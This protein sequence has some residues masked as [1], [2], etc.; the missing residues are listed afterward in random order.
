MKKYTIIGGVMT[1]LLVCTFIVI[2]ST[3]AN[4][5]DGNNGRHG[6]PKFEMTDEMKAAQEQMDT[7]I[8]NNDYETWK[9]LV[10]QLPDSS[11]MQVTEEAFAKLVER[12][13]DRVTMEE[14]QKKIEAAIDSGDYATWKSL[15]TGLPN[16]TEM[17]EKITAD[18]FAKFT[19]AHQLMKEAQAKMEEAKSIMEEIGLDG[20]QQGVPFGGGKGEGMGRMEHMGSRPIPMGQPES[21]EQK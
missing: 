12:Y 2:G 5:F 8:Q 4:G 19:E 3:Y 9:S 18:N 20:I 11:K 17:L 14:L 16:G 7:A 1:L 13:Q 15:V 10:S 6:G 21:A